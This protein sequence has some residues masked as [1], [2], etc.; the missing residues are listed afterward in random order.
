MMRKWSIVSG[1]V[2]IVLITGALV[3]AY[4]VAPAVV[5][6]PGDTNISRTFAG[7]ASSLLNPAAIASGNTSQAI[8]HNVP[9]IATHKTDVLDTTSSSAKIAD[10]KTLSAAG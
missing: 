10:T 3:C 7:T 5:K 2:G 8:L 6:L 1:V 9:I 4:A